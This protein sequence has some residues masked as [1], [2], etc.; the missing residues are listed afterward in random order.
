MER[1][2]LVIFNE[3]GRKGNR[4]ILRI[5]YVKIFPNTKSK[6]FQKTLYVLETHHFKMFDNNLDAAD[7]SRWVQFSLSYLT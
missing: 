3:G 5:Y 7:V 6:N 4:K 1:K 2:E